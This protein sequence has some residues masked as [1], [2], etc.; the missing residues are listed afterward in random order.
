MEITIFSHALSVAG[1]ADYLSTFANA[2]NFVFL[3]IQVV[4]IT[5]AIL[6]GGLFLRMRSKKSQT[7]RQSPED[8]YDDWRIKNGLVI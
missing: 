2:F 7:V 1:F 4:W 5:L 6:L 8:A 3:M